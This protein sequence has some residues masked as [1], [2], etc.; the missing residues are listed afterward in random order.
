MKS[1]YSTTCC[2][3]TGVFALLAPVAALHAAQS[4][5]RIDPQ[6]M[7]QLQRMSASLAAAKAFTYKSTTAQEVPAKTGQFLTIFSSAE[8]A[9]KRPDKLRAHVTGQAPHFDF[10]YDGA[11]ASAHAADAKIYSTTKAPPTMDAMLPEMEQE[12]GIRFVSMPLFFSDPYSVLSRRI[13]SALVAGSVAV[14]GV[15]CVHLAF[16]SPGV[17]WEIWIE[18][19]ARALPR[20]I[21]TT[22]TD[23]PNSPRTQVEFTSWNLHPWLSDGGFVF[24]PPAGAVEKPFKSV[25]KPDAR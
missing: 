16:K 10:Y 9:L 24:H 4:P 8:V 12:T 25:M 17:N 6:A 5:S 14:N 1:Y 21:A 19:G 20:R 13:S 15:E 11:T 18:S 22:F 2:R 3:I 23:R 7:G